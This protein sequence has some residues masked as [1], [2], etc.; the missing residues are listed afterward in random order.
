MASKHS[1]FS[2]LNW[3]DVLENNDRRTLEKSYAFFRFGPFY[4][5]SKVFP[6]TIFVAMRVPLN[7]LLMQYFFYLKNQIQFHP[8][9]N[10]VSNLMAQ[11]IVERYMMRKAKGEGNSLENKMCSLISNNLFLL[12]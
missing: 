1:T 10:I 9:V 8:I 12:K 7:Y 11:G 5:I 2:S 6:H 4:K 3:K